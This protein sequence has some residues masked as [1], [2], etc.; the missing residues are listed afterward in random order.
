MSLANPEINTG[1]AAGD[2]YTGIN[3]LVG[4]ASSDTLIGNA[5]NNWLVGGAGADALDGQGSGDRDA[6]AYWN[7][8]A[9]LTASLANPASNT[10]DADGDTYAN[11]E[12]LVGTQFADTLI[13]DGNDNFLVGTGGGDVLEGGLGSDTASY[14]IFTATV[15]ITADLANSAVNT[16]EAAGD[17]YISIENLTGTQFRRLPLW[18]WQQQRPEG[19]PRRRS[20]QRYASTDGP[21]PTP[22]SAGWVT[23]P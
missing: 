11:I 2:S 6:A 7:A 20:G 18:R 12:G 16:G 15:R 21:A 3:S 1:E 5:D 10:G 19:Q 13:G 8:T 14:T 4:S 23:T 22:C 9:G 17:T